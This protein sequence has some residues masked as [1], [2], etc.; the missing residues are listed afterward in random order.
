MAM[1]ENLGHVLDLGRVKVHSESGSIGKVVDEVSPRGQRFTH[2]RL[3]L[4]LI[5]GTRREFLFMELRDATE[6]E[7]ALF[8]PKGK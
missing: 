4:E 7:L 3:V 5:D 6:H 8:E 1:P 2:Y